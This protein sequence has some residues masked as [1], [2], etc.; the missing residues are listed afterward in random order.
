MKT[1]HPLYIGVN[2]Y[3]NPQYNLTGCVPDVMAMQAFFKEYCKT[4]DINYHDTE[5]IV[6]QKATR[7]GIIAAFDNAFK[8]VQDGDICILYYSGHGS[9]M[10]S[11]KEFW[12]MDTDRKMQTLVCHDSREP[13]N[14]DLSNKEISYLIWK[15]TYGK[16]VHFLTVFDSCHSGSITRGKDAVTHRMAD[17]NPTPAHLSDLEGSK[18]YIQTGEGQFTPPLAPHIA[19]SSCRTYESSVEMTIGNKR[20]GLFTWGFLET[21]KS[22]PLD[23]LTY[24]EL[25]S[26]INA[27]IQ[28]KYKH[29][30]PLYSTYH[31]F[32]ANQYFMSGELKSK[33]DAI[34]FYKNEKQKWFINQGEVH[35]LK[36]GAY[37]MC[38]TE[39][40]NQ[41]AE[42]EKTYAGE[43]EVSYK[44]WMNPQNQYDVLY[45]ENPETP[46]MVKIT[47]SD[48]DNTKDILVHTIN[49]NYNDIWIVDDNQQYNI[50]INNNQLQLI[51]PDAERPVFKSIDVNSAGAQQSIHLFLDNV[52]KVQ[53]WEHVSELSNPNAFMRL[54]DKVD[55][56]FEDILEHEDN[57]KIIKKERIDINGVHD[58]VYNYE[59]EDWIDPAFSLKIKNNSNQN[60]WIGALFLNEKYGVTDM[61]MPIK[62]IGKDDEPY[63]MKLLHDGY[64]YTI[65]PLQ[66]PEEVLSW[67]E[68]EIRNQIKIFI[69]TDEFKLNNFNQDDL[70][71]EMKRN[72][73]EIT[74]GVQEKGFGFKKKKSKKNE[75]DWTTID[76][77]FNI[78]RPTD[79]MS[80]ADNQQKSLNENVEIIAPSGL[81]A[82]K[83]RISTTQHTA[84]KGMGAPSPNMIL[85]TE[86]FNSV[87]LTP[88]ATKGDNVSNVLELHNVQ[89]ADNV[90]KD[91]PLL[92]KMKEK[93]GAHIMPFA[94]GDDGLLYPIG[95]MKGDTIHIEQLPS[96]TEVVTKGLGKSIKIYFSELLRTK[97]VKLEAAYPLLSEVIISK[98][99]VEQ[100]TEVSEI[101]QKIQEDSTQRILIVTH[102]IIGESADKFDVF[103][104]NKKLKESYDLILGFDYESLGTTI[105]QNAELFKEKL[106]AVGIKA[107]H[108]KTVHLVAH[109]MGGLISRYYLEQLGGNAVISHFIM[110]G[111]PN[112]GSPLANVYDLVSMGL[113]KAIN[114]IP[115]SGV[116]TTVMKFA[117]KYWTKME[118]SLEQ[119]EVGSDI[120]KMLKDSSVGIPYTIVSGDYK[121]ATNYD[122]KETK[123]YKKILKRYKEKALDDLL[124]K[125]KS[126]AVVALS[127][128]QGLPDSDLVNYIDAIGSN[129][130]NYFNS[131]EG[132]D[133]LATIL[134]DLK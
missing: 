52:N 3:S 110:V 40:G 65:I 85:G 27:K 18:D 25:L 46:L 86:L 89:G 87:N 102:G 105:E 58:F 53:H 50:H 16:D 12:H 108:G 7:K 77:N 4:S 5:P 72:I 129:H 11:P 83:V 68:N 81:S 44:S 130:F 23:K 35:G 118:T 95:Y 47:H 75:R 99:E 101:K 66:F 122:K 123:L 100:N 74:R 37:I 9:Q 28:N 97:V 59:D 134:S 32:D 30:H 115:M 98:E 10:P 113:G 107:G 57:V 62:E 8:D 84:T 79:G 19:L 51:R 119:L 96:A 1:L 128:Q 125:G 91:N 126:D 132:M 14:R 42:I 120:T 49:E 43:A 22:N 104:E 63:P 6:N 69:S 93:D 112:L 13:G 38:Q 61:L 33:S 55:I 133:A 71:L 36:Q 48:N 103:K 127:S 73:E 78:I 114:F 64:D 106:E 121:K 20:R 26:K 109:S 34:V 29:Q 15:Y 92:L 17:P 39:E 82:E 111:T 116:I 117:T 21:L 67:G 80:I 70:E 31:G 94:Y 54:E 90:N 56:V 45:I 60:L 41:K 24:D 76:L 88:F 124:F 131:K 2:E